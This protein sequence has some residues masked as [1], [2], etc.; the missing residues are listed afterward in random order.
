MGGKKVLMFGGSSGGELQNDFLMVD[1]ALPEPEWMQPLV[2]G[3]EVEPRVNA[4]MQMVGSL[5]YLTGGMAKDDEEADY[6]CEDMLVFQYDARLNTL[7]YQ[8]EVVFTGMAPQPRHSGLFTPY[9]KDKLLL[10]AGQDGKNKPL[11][12]MHLLDTVKGT[13]R[14]LFAG[15]PEQCPPFG[16]V[17]NVVNGRI[18]TMNLSGPAAARFDNVQSVDPLSLM[19]KYNFAKFMTEVLEEDL[20]Q[21]EAEVEMMNHAVELTNDTAALSGNFENLTKVMAGLYSI[22]QMRVRIDL[23]QEQLK[24][25]C[26]VLGKSKVNVSKQEAQLEDLVLRWN[27]VKTGAP[28]A[29]DNVG[30]IQMAEGERIKGDIKVFTDKCRDFR[31]AYKSK[32]F[33][34]ALSLI[35]I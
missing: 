6:L 15:D 22:K 29:K 1:L 9:G 27:D 5:V 8:P 17:G 28:Q 18:L 24:E 4:M 30:P 23:R 21:M 14:I 7:T 16:A 34:E 19:E 11:N 32:A 10:Y 20:A 26:G 25:I 31:I 33:Y 2:R 35:H 3:L 13:W 12:T